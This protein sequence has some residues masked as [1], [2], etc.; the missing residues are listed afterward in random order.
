MLFLVVFLDP[1]LL[2]G[3]VV[4]FI[5]SQCRR[6]L[7]EFLEFLQSLILLL[8]ISQ[9]EQAVY[10]FLLFF[11]GLHLEKLFEGKDFVVFEVFETGLGLLQER[12]GVDPG[13]G[14]G[15]VDFV[16]L[17]FGNPVRLENEHG[18]Q[19]VL[20]CVGKEIS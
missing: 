10:L 16:L 7:F 3:E 17:L 15:G 6:L 5:N 20:D 4:A 8:V 1:V 2:W 14:L 11:S 13:S 12:F 18:L 9:L 19:L